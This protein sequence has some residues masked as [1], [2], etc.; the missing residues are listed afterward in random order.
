[1]NNSLKGG[2][3]IR[4]LKKKYLWSNIFNLTCLMNCEIFFKQKESRGNPLPYP[5]YIKHKTKDNTKKTGG[6]S[7]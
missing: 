2:Q 7:T 4:T 3:I 6:T 1:M 5:K